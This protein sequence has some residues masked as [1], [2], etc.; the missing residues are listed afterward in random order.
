MDASDVVLNFTRMTGIA[1]NEPVAAFDE[2]GNGR[3]G[4]AGIVAVFNEVYRSFYY[5][6]APVQC[7][8]ILRLALIA[9]IPGRAI[10]PYP[11]DRCIVPSGWK[12]QA[13]RPV[14]AA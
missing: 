2:N 13:G 11:G 3:I 10:D 12:D 4:S 6:N 8:I 14:P 9:K 1:D 5:C 7:N